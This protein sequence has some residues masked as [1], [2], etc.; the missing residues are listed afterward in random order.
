MICAIGLPRACGGVSESNLL[1]GIRYSSSPR[2][3]GCFLMRCG[4][5]YQSEVFPAHAGVFP[6]G[7]SWQRRKR[8]LPRACGG[9]SRFYDG[10]RCLKLS[11]PRMRGCFRHVSTGV[12]FTQ[13]LPRACGGVSIHLHQ[14]AYFLG[15]SPR[16]RG[17]FPVDVDRAPG[18]LVFPAHAGVFPPRRCTAFPSGRLPRACGG[19]SSTG[20]PDSVVAWS[21]PRMRG[22]F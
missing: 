19:V 20:L 17:C 2:M 7:S 22:C 3:R 5:T 13:S 10:F 16:M 18:R 1:F 6:K 9:V 11:S 14:R 12:H 8:R 4:Q 15:S 21:S